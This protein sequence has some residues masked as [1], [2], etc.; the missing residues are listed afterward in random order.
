[1]GP[2]VGAILETPVGARS[3]GGVGRVVALGSTDAVC[4]S[5]DVI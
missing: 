5:T 3:T 4:G 2:Q 1:M